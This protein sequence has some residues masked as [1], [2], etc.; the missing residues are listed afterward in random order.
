MLSTRQSHQ[1][2]ASLISQGLSGHHP[3]FEPELVRF[4]MRRADGPSLS[5]DAAVRLRTVVR[6]METSGD[7]RERREWVAG[8]PLEVQETLVRAYFDAL[9]AYLDMQPIL[10]N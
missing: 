5:P 3:L 4:T 1:R 9:F 10:A 6:G 8:A 2:W 7:A